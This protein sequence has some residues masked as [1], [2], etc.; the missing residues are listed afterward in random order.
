[1]TPTSIIH[2]LESHTLATQERV[3]LSQIAAKLEAYRLDHS[4]HWLTEILSRCD[5]GIGR[6]GE[7]EETFRR[8]KA[9]VEIFRI[10]GDERLLTGVLEMKERDER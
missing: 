1:M 6:Q 10:C 4:P 5:A 9:K 3:I 7:C 2:A 8:V